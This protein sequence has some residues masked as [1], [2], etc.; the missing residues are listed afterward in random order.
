MNSEW[1]FYMR[2]NGRIK[3]G[4]TFQSKHSQINQFQSKLR[5]YYKQIFIQIKEFICA[6]IGRQS[7]LTMR[8]SCFEKQLIV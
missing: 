3:L 7:A 1:F 8:C 2:K 4:K 5:K 6:K